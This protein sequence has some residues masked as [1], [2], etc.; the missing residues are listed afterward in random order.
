MELDPRITAVIAVV[1]SA[2]MASVP[3]IVT[4]VTGRRPLFECYCD[5]HTHNEMPRSHSAP[6][7]R[8]VLGTSTATSTSTS[9]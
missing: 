1:T 8:Y 9:T 7:A 5:L 4:D 6:Y 2:A 3:C